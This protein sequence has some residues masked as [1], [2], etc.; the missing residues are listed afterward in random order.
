[1]LRVPLP[2]LPTLPPDPEPLPPR[3]TMLLMFLVLLP[4]LLLR[5]Y[6]PGIAIPLAPLADL[7]FRWI[8]RLL[9]TQIP[10]AVPLFIQDRPLLFDLVELNEP[11]P[12]PKLLGIFCKIIEPPKLFVPAVI[13]LVI[14]DTVSESSYPPPPVAT[15]ADRLR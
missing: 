8:I 5:P 2:P 4:D 12:P 6:G 14:C 15:S 9:P 7:F 3:F 13:L 10:V 11:L 1:M